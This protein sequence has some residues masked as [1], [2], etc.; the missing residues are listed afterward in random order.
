[1][2]AAAHERAKAEGRLVGAADFLEALF[3]VEAAAGTRLAVRHGLN[4][5]A[6][7]G[8]LPARAEPYEP[9]EV[10]HLELTPSGMD[11]FGGAIHGAGAVGAKHIATC[12]L[13]ASLFELGDEEIDAWFERVGVTGDLVE[14]ALELT[15]D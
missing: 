3:T 7:A 10:D 14:E 6:L 4:P 11:A 8:W 13:L 2:W 1:M 12:H 9:S 5:P 15:E